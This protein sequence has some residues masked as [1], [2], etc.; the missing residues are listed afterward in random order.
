[1][2]YVYIYIYLIV[3]VYINIHN[4]DDIF[5][6]VYID[7]VNALIDKSTRRNQ[8][9]SSVPGVPDHWQLLAEFEPGI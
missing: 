7:S 4:Y 5:I 3:F 9:G 1:M 2:I 6:Y 8:N